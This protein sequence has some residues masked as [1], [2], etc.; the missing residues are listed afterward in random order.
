MSKTTG[1]LIIGIR[2]DCILIDDPLD[3]SQAY[4][5][6]AALEETNQWVDQSLSS[7]KN[8]PTVPRILIMQR[9]HERDPSGHMLEQDGW[10]H[11]CL[12]NEYDGK[13]HHTVI[14]YED[15]RTE[16]GE[17]L[18]TELFGPED[19][20]RAKDVLGRIGYAGQY[21]QDPLPADGVIFLE[22]WFQFWDPDELPK[23]D[24][25]IGSWD[26]NDLE[27][28]KK[29]TKDTDYVVGQLWGAHGL[30]RYLIAQTRAKLNQ[31]QSGNMIAE[32]FERPGR[33]RRPRDR[34]AP[35]GARSRAGQEEGRQDQA[36]HR[37]PAHR[38]Q[39]GAR[40]RVSPPAPG[41]PV[42]QERQGRVHP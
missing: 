25:L 26:L 3:A 31:I 10:V 22:A 39:R 17:L 14:G 38:V 4:A 6:K 33:D 36:C 35:P 41:P 11:L 28:N 40:P 23:F 16:E 20:A 27:H 21:Q 37:L 12:P 32:M 9:L 8:R 42:G 2:G 29:A 5:D 15:P 24:M 7:R 30:D 18:F 1:Q 19:T 13:R 34:A